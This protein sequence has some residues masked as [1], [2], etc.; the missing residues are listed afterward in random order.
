MIHNAHV[1]SKSLENIVDQLDV[2]QGFAVSFRSITSQEG[3]LD[4]HDTT[5]AKQ[6]AYPGAGR[7]IN[8]E[9]PHS[10]G[11]ATMRWCDIPS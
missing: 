7:D 2:I 3:S 5:T 4:K 1:M 9:I 6:C 11:I 10:R 8:F